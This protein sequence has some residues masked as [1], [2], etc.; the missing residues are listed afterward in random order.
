MNPRQKRWMRVGQNMSHRMKQIVLCANFF[1]L[2]YSFVVVK[3]YSISLND[4]H[5]ISHIACEQS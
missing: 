2:I 3:Q 5:L 1:F 4:E